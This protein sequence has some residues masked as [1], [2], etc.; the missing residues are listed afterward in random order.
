MTGI[1]KHGK[2]AGGTFTM[3]TSSFPRAKKAVLLCSLILVI[4]HPTYN[5]LPLCSHL[6]L[7]SKTQ[8]QTV[9]DN[10]SLPCTVFINNNRKHGFIQPQAASASESYMNHQT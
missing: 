1:T 6:K 3:H 7:S 9:V 5:Q 4:S 2:T 10:F 8:G